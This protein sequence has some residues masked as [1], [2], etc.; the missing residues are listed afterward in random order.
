LDVQATKVR[1]VK[2][3]LREQ[4]HKP[5]WPFPSEARLLKRERLDWCRTFSKRP[6]RSFDSKPGPPLFRVWAFEHPARDGGTSDARVDRAI[7]TWIRCVVLWRLRSA[8][9]IV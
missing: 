9:W 2:N 7:A 4:S 1:V 8:M 3:V 6:A 5:S